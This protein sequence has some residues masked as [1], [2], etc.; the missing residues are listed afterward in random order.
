MC[1][2]AQNH[3]AGRRQSQLLPAREVMLQDDD[4]EDDGGKAARAKPPKEE[5]AA[6]FQARTGKRQIYR[7]HA[8]DRQT[9]TGI[10]QDRPVEFP[11]DLPNDGCPERHP[12]DKG[13]R[14]TGTLGRTEQ[15]MLVL[16]CQRPEKN[17]TGEGGDKPASTENL[18]YGEA[19]KGQRDHRE[20]PPGFGDPIALRTPFQQPTSCC[21]K[22]EPDGSADA[23]LLR[24]QNQCKLS[25]TPFHSR[26]GCEG[27]EHE[28]NG[29]ADS[30]IEYAFNVQALPLCYRN[31]R[32][33]HD[34]LSQ[35]GVGRS[36]HGRK[37]CNL[38]QGHAGE[39]QD[40]KA[41]SEQNGQR[42]TN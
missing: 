18:G 36:Q 25:P 29:N 33:R 4:G 2:D 10:N 21:R 37:H 16:F 5:S 17:A 30:V 24:D 22:A 1:E 14:V 8:N 34:G 31:G 13:H 28:Q 23:Y 26:V 11:D 7:Q 15:I 20:L 38:E 39:H 19:H 42:K 3:R 32:I 9:E 35:C 41:E 12:G 27:E 6:R 40:T